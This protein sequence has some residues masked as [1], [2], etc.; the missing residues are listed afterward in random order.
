MIMSIS[1][2]NKIYMYGAAQKN[3]KLSLNVLIPLS[4]LKFLFTI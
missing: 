2:G 4:P 1:N 3:F